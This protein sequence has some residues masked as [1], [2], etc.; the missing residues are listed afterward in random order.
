M[1]V[2]VKKIFVVTPRGGL[3]NQLITIVNGI[4]YG[5]YF[6]R[7]VHFNGFQLDYKNNNEYINVDSILNF[8]KMQILINKLEL[9]TNMLVSVDYSKK[10]KKIE[11]IDI[12]IKDLYNEI[13]KE[14]NKEIDI[15]NIGN[16]INVSLPPNDKLNYSNI[17]Y[18]LSN[19]IEFADD[20]IIRA[21]IIKKSLKLSNYACIHMRLE[22]D[23]LDYYSKYF[24]INIYTFNTQTQ[25]NYLNEIHNIQKI[26]KN[27]YVCSSLIIQDNVNNDFYKE[28][29]DKYMLLDKNHLINKDDLN[30]YREL[31]AIIDFIIAKDANCFI[32]NKPSSFSNCINNYFNLKNKHS[33]LI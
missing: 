25:T 17:F 16:L 21:N 18:I 1:S 20:Y 10:Y 11:N 32:G 3:C 30:K 14:D 5:D 22:D 6:N 26:Y 7:D 12:S 33:K 8:K 29:K 31:Y 24:G 28:I 23:A 4:I 9:S 13:N 19:S 27:I 15:L 2:S